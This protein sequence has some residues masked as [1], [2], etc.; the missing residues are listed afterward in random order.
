M[1]RL[2]FV[3]AFRKLS[4]SK[5]LKIKILDVGCGLGFLSCLCAEFYPNAVITGVDTFKHQSLKGA[6]IDKARANASILGFAGRVRF[7]K[8]DVLKSDFRRDSFDLF[9]SNL[10]Y[11][12]FGRKRFAAYERLASWVPRGSYVVLGDLFFDCGPDINRLSLLFGSVKEMQITGIESAYKLLVLSD[13]RWT[14]NASALIGASN[15]KE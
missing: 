9:V 7:E 15:T 6:S 14:F 1:L 4:F 10:V 11:H 3:D 2:I 5:N 13:P 8:G 12:N